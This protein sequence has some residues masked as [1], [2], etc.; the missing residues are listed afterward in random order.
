[1][2]QIIYNQNLRVG[3]WV[4][5]RIG[6]IFTKRDSVC[7]G[8]E[9]NREIIAG[10][11]Y[12]NYIKDICIDMHV[13]GINNWCSKEFIQAAFYYPFLQ[14][15]VKKVIAKIDSKNNK[16][17]EFAKKLGGIHEATLKD[18][19]RYGDLLIFTLTLEQFK[20]KGKNYGDFKSK[21]TTTATTIKFKP[22]TA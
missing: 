3:T 19:S 18:A 22:A 20:Y 11:V 7:I 17:I 15:G 1:M 5:E 4:C 8:L 13:A 14:L 10:F 16:G 6:G 2:R 9:S 21:A 12:N